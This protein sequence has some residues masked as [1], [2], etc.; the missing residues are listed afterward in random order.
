M[1]EV[2]F[3][4][5]PP[6]E[7][8]PL[9]EAVERE[10]HLREGNISLILE[11]YD[12]IFSDFD[13]RPT[14]ERALSDDFLSECRRAAHDRREKEI[15]L[16]LMVPKVNRNLEEEAKIKH[17]LKAHFHKHL[18]EK[19]EEI[20]S[21][22]NEGWR[23]FSLGAICM[24]VGAYLYTSGETGG[25]LGL[26]N[27]NFFYHMLIMI[28]EPAG[29]FLVWEGMDQILLATKEHKHELLFYEKMAQSRVEFFGY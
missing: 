13:P 25:I 16:R 10:V 27:A 24:I 29:W 20:N 8:I 14:P 4:D 23:W 5:R 1:E 28:F 26:T 17:R 18:Q 19:G 22:K 12:D 3:P 15:E 7:K 6:L 9:D 11:S 2:R 21:I